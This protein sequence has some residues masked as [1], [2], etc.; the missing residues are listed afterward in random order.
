LT[1]KNVFLKYLSHVAIHSASLVSS[2]FGRISKSFAQFVEKLN[3][4]MGRMT[5]LRPMKD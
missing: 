2:S 3:K 1:K 5:F 4:Y